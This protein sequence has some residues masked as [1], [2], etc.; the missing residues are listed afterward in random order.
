M[1]NDYRWCLWERRYLLCGPF[2]YIYF[3]HGQNYFNPEVLTNHVGEYETFFSFFRVFFGGFYLENYWDSD[4]ISNLAEGL[5]A[6]GV[7]GFTKNDVTTLTQRFI[8][9][10]SF[11]VL[12]ERRR[13]APRKRGVILFSYITSFTLSPSLALHTLHK[14][15]H[16]QTLLG[17]S[18]HT[19]FTGKHPTIFFFFFLKTFFLFLRMRPCH[20]ACNANVLST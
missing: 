11:F 16:T 18:S 14:I 1:Q 3:F 19:H 13:Q 20:V 10:F 6:R 15:A 12:L 5:G 2:I 4:F 9:W 8:I 7:V 17:S